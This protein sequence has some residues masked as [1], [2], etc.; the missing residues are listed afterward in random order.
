MVEGKSAS[1][2]IK[3]DGEL[4]KVYEGIFEAVSEIAIHLRY[5]TSSKIQT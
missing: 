1:E 4:G 2:N 5:S 3:F